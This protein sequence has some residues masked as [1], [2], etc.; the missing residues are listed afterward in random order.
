MYDPKKDTGKTMEIGTDP[1]EILMVAVIMG[2]KGDQRCEFGTDHN[3]R[4]GGGIDC[5]RRRRHRDCTGTTIL[6]GGFN[7][8]VILALV[9]V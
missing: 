5:R 8:R 7:V 3:P 6:V 9:L 2:I 1:I 4:H